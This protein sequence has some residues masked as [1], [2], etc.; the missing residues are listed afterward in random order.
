VGRGHAEI[1]HESDFDWV[2]VP[3]SGWPSGAKIRIL[4]RDDETGALSGVLRL[5]AGYER[6][7]GQL[8]AAAELFVLEGTLRIGDAIAERGHF[9]HAPAAAAQ[10]PWRTELGATVFLMTRGSAD[11]SPGG[12]GADPAGRIRM[13]TNRIPWVGQATAGPPPGIF[14]KR[15]RYDEATGERVFLCSMVPRYDYPMIEYHDCAEES[16]V[17]KGD[18]RMGTSGLMTAGSYFW[19]P[20]YITHGPFYCRDGFLALMYVDSLLINHYVEDPRR[21]AEENRAEA[22]A[23]KRQ[24]AA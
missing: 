6:P 10:E 21:T 20:A 3:A 8:P 24:A 14:S 9:E 7:E 23:K 15:L 17:L 2:D 16:Y 13:D 1:V 19:R 22:E 4:S 12:G 11:F 18:V 5:P